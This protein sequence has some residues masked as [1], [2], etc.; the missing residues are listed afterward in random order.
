MT[1]MGPW[2]FWD[3]PVLPL[4]LTL[5]YFLFCEGVSCIV[6]CQTNCPQVLSTNV[7][8]NFLAIGILIWSCRVKVDFEAL[9]FVTSI[10]KQ[11]APHRLLGGNGF[12]TKAHGDSKVPWSHFL[13]CCTFMRLWIGL[14]QR[15][16]VGQCFAV[17]PHMHVQP[18]PQTDRAQPQSHRQICGVLFPPS[19]R[20]LWCAA[21]ILFVLKLWYL[22]AAPLEASA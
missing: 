3:A 14:G 13:S 6:S 4:A 19:A 8:I 21:I 16:R 1:R 12:E 20:S 10:T 22:Q 17:V 11:V 18:R 2:G 7:S 15:G 5:H 9:S